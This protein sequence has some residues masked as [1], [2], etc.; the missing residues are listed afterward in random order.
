MSVVKFISTVK[1]SPAD[2]TPV[3]KNR[4][5]EPILSNYM[6]RPAFETIAA[7]I[8]DTLLTAPQSDET[9]KTMVGLMLFFESSLMQNT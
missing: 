5:T 6:S 2:A 3:R 1:V 8:N 4:G 7:M 9:A